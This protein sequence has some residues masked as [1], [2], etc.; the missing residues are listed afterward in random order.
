[1][2]DLAALRLAA[3]RSLA[4]TRVAVEAGKVTRAANHSMYRAKPEIR[5]AARNIVSD[6]RRSRSHGN[7]IIKQLTF[8]T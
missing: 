6:V 7:T 5:I 1:V 2:L 8:L 3:D 4:L